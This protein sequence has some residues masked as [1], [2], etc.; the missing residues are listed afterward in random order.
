MNPSHTSIPSQTSDTY[1]PNLQS[2]PPSDTHEPQGKGS[3]RDT[4]PKLSSKA[5]NTEDFWLQLEALHRMA[6][7]RKKNR[8]SSE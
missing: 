2:A 7:E 3:N 8:G 1:N 5:D 4:T 6:Q